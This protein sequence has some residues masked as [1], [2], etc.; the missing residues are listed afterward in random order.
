LIRCQIDLLRLS[1]GIR[2]RVHKLLD[3]TE[4]DISSFDA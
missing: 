2:N 1:G 3:A 4:D